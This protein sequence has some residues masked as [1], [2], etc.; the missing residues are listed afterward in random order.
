M[1]LT[2]L[3]EARYAGEHPIVKKIKAEIA[4]DGYVAPRGHFFI[5]I[6]DGI[7]AENAEKGII[8]AFGP[9][10]SQGPATEDEYFSFQY[11]N[12]IW[13]LNHERTLQIVWVPRYKKIAVRRG[14]AA[15]VNFE[16]QRGTTMEIALL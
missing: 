13:H 9:P 15:P 5:K 4:N 14:Q 2:Q 12:M 8:T 3:Q 16:R 6:E 10:D 7:K 11:R 1:K